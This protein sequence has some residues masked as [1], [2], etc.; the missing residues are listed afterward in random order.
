MHSY[1]WQATVCN[2]KTSDTVEKAK[3]L[4]GFTI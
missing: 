4:E 2:I 1:G 3:R